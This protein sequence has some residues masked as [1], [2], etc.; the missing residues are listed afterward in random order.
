MTLEEIG[1]RA[2]KWYTVFQ[3]INDPNQRVKD[4]GPQI[5][6]NW[7]KFQDACKE[8]YENPPHSEATS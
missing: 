2:M 7:E 5:T 3:F 6:E 8:F 4:Y 1:A